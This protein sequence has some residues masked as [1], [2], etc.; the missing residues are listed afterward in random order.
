MA[1]ALTLA[2]RQSL[3]AEATDELWLILLTIEADGLTEPI[4][5]VNDRQDLYSR[6][7]RYVAYPFELDLPADDGETVAR[8]MIRIDNVDR[9]ILAAV[10]A[11]TGL[12]RATI[13][14][15]RRA[16]PDVVE[17]GPFSMT[18]AELRADALTLEATCVYEDILDAAF[19][20]GQY[21]PA[22]YP[23]L[24]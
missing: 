16:E 19:P 21:T 8:V 6:G 12:P 1:R 2:A 5:V 15:V 24:F 7:A 9:A 17:A 10:R 13:E 18:V 20:A 23:G 3:T 22:D 11:A 4:R 14:V